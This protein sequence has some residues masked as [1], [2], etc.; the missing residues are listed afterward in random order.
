LPLVCTLNGAPVL[1]AVATL[2]RVDYDE[3]DRLALS[4][5]AGA[6]GLTLVPYLE[7]ERSPNLPDAA[8]ALQGMTVRNLT[9]ANIARAAVE[10]LLCS[11]AYC[12]DKIAAQGVEAER[13]ILV[14]GGVRSEAV[15]ALAPAIFGK[16]V[17]VPTPAEYVALG[18]AR[19]AAWTLAQGDSPPGWSFGI[20]T[21]FTAAATPE[22]VDQYRRAQPLTLGQ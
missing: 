22:V 8:G 21:M 17:L 13:I 12:L 11:L 16:P 15:R 1:A 2:L 9:A 18:A 6:E 19:Q 4:A 20:T 7:G 5:S 14:G 10:G 3:L